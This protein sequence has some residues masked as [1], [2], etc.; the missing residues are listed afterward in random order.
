MR[1]AFLEVN[2]YTFFAPEGEVIRTFLS[3]AEGKVTLEELAQWFRR[4]S[5]SN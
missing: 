2:G 4:F 1:T 3:L 5:G